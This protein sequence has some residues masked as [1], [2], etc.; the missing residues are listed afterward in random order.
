MICNFPVFRTETYEYGR[1][2]IIENVA[3][4]RARRADFQRKS[5]IGLVMAFG[6]KPRRRQFSFMPSEE[7]LV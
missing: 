1:A 2:D 4:G 7:E 5:A 3:R 6:N